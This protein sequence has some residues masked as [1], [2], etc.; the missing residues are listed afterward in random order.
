M[1]SRDMCKQLLCADNDDVNGREEECL[2]GVDF[3]DMIESFWYYNTSR[4]TRTIPPRLLCRL[5][6]PT[7]DFATDPFPPGLPTLQI[8]LLSLDIPQDQDLA[9]SDSMNVPSSSTRQQSP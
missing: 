8:S 9:Q 2:P 4:P 5:T 7:D 6:S 3:V 1:T